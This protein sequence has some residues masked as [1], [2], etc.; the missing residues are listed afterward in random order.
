MGRHY[1]IWMTQG[2]GCGE[3]PAAECDSIDEALDIAASMF[4]EG[5]VA[6]ELPD[7]SWHEFG[8]AW[9]MPVKVTLLRMRRDGLN[10]KQEWLLGQWH[11]AVGDQPLKF[12]G[13]G[14]HTFES[15]LRELER[16]LKHGEAAN[17]FCASLAWGL[18]DI[19]ECPTGMM[20][21]NEQIDWILAGKTR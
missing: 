19:F 9:D 10:P 11:Q 13:K 20:P 2:R 3:Q 15:V 17:L 18:F 5:S 21:T 14:A 8:K 7:G 6:V 16:G 1:R 4:G 12:L